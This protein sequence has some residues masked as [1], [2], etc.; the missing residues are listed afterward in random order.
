MSAKN[1]H[2]LDKE[3]I[4]TVLDRVVAPGMLV[5]E[6]GA[7]EL[8]RIPGEVGRNLLPLQAAVGKEVRL[9]PAEPRVEPRRKL[10]LDPDRVAER[11][12]APAGV[13]DPVAVGIQAEFMAALKQLAAEQERLVLP[14]SQ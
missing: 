10:V 13:E 1:D 11:M 8:A 5:R 2:Q 7:E 3:R 9:V 4:Q 14:L 12:G 6:S